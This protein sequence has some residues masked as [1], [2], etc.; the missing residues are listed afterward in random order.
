MLKDDH[1]IQRWR[2]GV[3]FRTFL[4]QNRKCIFLMSSSEHFGSFLWYIICDLQKFCHMKWRQLKG[5][6][7]FYVTSFLRQAANQRF[8]PAGAETMQR[9]QAFFVARCLCHRPP[10][11]KPW[12]VNGV[13]RLQDFGAHVLLSNLQL[14]WKLATGV[15]ESA[16]KRSLQNP[17]KN[18]S[19]IVPLGS[20]SLSSLKVWECLLSILEILSKDPC[21]PKSRMTTP[22]RTNM[23]PENHPIETET[24][25]ESEP[26][27]LH[28]CLR[29]EFSQLKS[30]PF[31]FHQRSRPRRQAWN[32]LWWF[33][34]N[35]W[36]KES[37]AAAS[38]KIQTQTKMDDN[39]IMSVHLILRVYMMYLYY[40]YMSNDCV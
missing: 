10:W 38:R 12:E 22:L 27:N 21:H 3:L 28:F 37:G 8:P 35:Y 17:S 39:V 40:Y 9:F 1:S 30:P 13:Q 14:T 29:C 18:R 31:F 16:T 6:S 23:K 7:P 2:R 34:T 36:K 19:L 4:D 11:L 24:H 33:V 5:N 26:E 20:M 32:H 25:L 15:K